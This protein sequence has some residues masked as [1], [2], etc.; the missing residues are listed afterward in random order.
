MNLMPAEEAKLVVL[1]SGPEDLRERL[2]P[3]FEAIG[4]RTM[5]IDGAAG[6]GTRLKL[7]T[8]SWV[9][10]VVEGTAETIALTE[11]LG[12]DPR[13]VLEALSGGTL[14]LPYLQMKGNAI[15]EN[16]F[17][18][19]FRLKL[20]TKDARLIEEAAKAREL[21]LPMISLIHERFAQ[22]AQ[23]HGDED[24]IATYFTSAPGD[25]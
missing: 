1:A 23:Q 18:P 20:A 15:I 17:E 16:N 12:L 21:D 8:N 9:L 4:Q 3:I 2:D 14:D 19:S 10:T 22:G 24:M 25:R 6:A 13:L 7:A 11:G 5:W